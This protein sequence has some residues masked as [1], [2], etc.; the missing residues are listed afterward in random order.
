[1]R[2]LVLFILFSIFSI[3]LCV[4]AQ[5]VNGGDS[6][7]EIVANEADA[8]SNL[9]DEDGED[10]NEDE[11]EELDSL[12]DIADKDVG[13]LSTVNVT[14]SHK[15]ATAPALQTEVSTVSRQKE[16]RWPF[17]GSRLR[18]LQRNDSA[19]RSQNYSRCTS[20]GAGRTGCS[21]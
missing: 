12:L 14:T 20:H 3:P 19:V 21:N 5:G 6:T 11:D 10:S 16:Y 15:N 13:Q 9:N 4:S 8:D 7:D 1:M 17:A 18:H 2:Q